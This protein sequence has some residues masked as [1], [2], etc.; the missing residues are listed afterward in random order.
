VIPNPRTPA[1]RD[2]LQREGLHCALAFLNRRVDYRFT[3]LYCFDGPLLQNV[4]LYDRQAPQQSGGGDAA[5][6]STW[7][8]ITGTSGD[9]LEIRDGRHDPRFPWMQGSPV[10]S[11][12]GAPVFESRGEAIGT[13]CHFDLE[14]RRIAK[15]ELPAVRAAAG[16]L[17]TYCLAAHAGGS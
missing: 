13:L 12:F 15:G 1:F 7:C 4:C 3:G 6:R 17:W 10:I 9:C 11:Y 8:G 16:L 14:P 2:V 5:L